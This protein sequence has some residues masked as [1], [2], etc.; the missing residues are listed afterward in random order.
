MVL[1]NYEFYDQHAT[2][3]TWEREGS[4]LVLNFTHSSA[5]T[6]AGTGN[7]QA[8]KWMGFPPMG[9]FRLRVVA[10]TGSDMHLQWTSEQGQ[11]YNYKFKKTW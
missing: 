11:V 5:D 4:D 10:L 2:N 9:V 8:P 6:P 1:L 7:Y 3:A